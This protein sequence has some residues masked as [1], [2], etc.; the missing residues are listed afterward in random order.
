MIR[1]C[2]CEGFAT[3]LK[4]IA[5]KRG[6]MYKIEETSDKQTF[7][8]TIERIQTFIIIAGRRVSSGYETDVPVIMIIH[9]I[10]TYRKFSLLLFN[11]ILFRQLGKAIFYFF[12]I[13]TQV[14]NNLNFRD[15]GFPGKKFQD[16]APRLPV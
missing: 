16:H 4:N 14:L 12:L 5:I 13:Y 3:M 1:W 10:S 7:L 8:R 11:K 9:Y 15:S 2:R 6:G